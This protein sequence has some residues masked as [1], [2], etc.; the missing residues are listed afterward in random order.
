MVSDPYSVFSFAAGSDFSVW[1]RDFLCEGECE[2]TGETARGQFSIFG[3]VEEI[4][5]RISAKVGTQASAQAETTKRMIGADFRME[6]FARGMGRGAGG[7]FST[8]SAQE[9]NRRNVERGLDRGRFVARISAG[10]KA[11]V[12]FEDA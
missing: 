7:E 8:E 2:C 5:L 4:G 6:S 9:R 1:S 12:S 10:A 11:P 3:A